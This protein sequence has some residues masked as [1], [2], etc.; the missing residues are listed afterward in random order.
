MSTNILKGEK[1]QS[2]QV[3]YIV[4]YKQ[5]TNEQKTSPALKEPQTIP[6]SLKAKR[7][8]LPYTP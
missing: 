5:K 2:I 3:V 8:P 6:K 7:T 1:P 4:A